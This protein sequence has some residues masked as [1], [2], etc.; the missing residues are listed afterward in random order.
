MIKTNENKKDCGCLRK[1]TYQTINPNNPFEELSA[2]IFPED[3]KIIENIFEPCQ[4]HSESGM[5]QKW[6]NKRL[7]KINKKEN[8]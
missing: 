2:L 7:E 3:G 8:K 5:F 6:K 1:V 4:D